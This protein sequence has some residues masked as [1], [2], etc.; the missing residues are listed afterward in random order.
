MQSISFWEKQELDDRMFRERDSETTQMKI[1]PRQMPLHH[2]TSRCWF[3]WRFRSMCSHLH[4]RCEIP[5]GSSPWFS[6]QWSLQW[7]PNYQFP[8]VC[9]ESQ[10]SQHH[11]KSSNVLSMFRICSFVLIKLQ[12][13]ALPPKNHHGQFALW[14]ESHHP[15]NFRIGFSWFVQ[16]C[17]VLTSQMSL[18]LGIACFCKPLKC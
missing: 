15:S 10:P 7:I 14:L 5:M 2:I 1:M 12:F 16:S 4:A 3:P 13:L 18:G 9:F 6:L 17:E 8:A 11:C